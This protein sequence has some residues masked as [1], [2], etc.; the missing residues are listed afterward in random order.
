[1]YGMFYK[2]SAFNQP[3]DNWD[4]SSVT[5]MAAMFYAASAFNQNLCH[6][7]NHYNR[8]TE[9]K[10]MFDDTDCQDTVSP[11]SADGPWCKASCP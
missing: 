1:M 10:N 11:T 6:F 5:D 4:V 8:R 9:Y 3:L 2:A 7:G